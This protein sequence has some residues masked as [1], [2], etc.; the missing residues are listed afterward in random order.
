MELKV[1]KKLSYIETYDWEMRTTTADIETIWKLLNEQQFINLWN[2]LINRSNIK[3]VFTKELTD[4]DKLIYSIED[5]TIRM[6]VQS[7]VEK[8]IKEWRRV[9]VDVVQN[10]IAKY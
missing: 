2:E 5:R 8:R 3:R 10:L 6:K 1:Y 4:V 7:D 9:N